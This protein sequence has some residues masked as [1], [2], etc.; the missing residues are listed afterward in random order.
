MKYTTTQEFEDAPRPN[1]SM[2]MPSGGTVY[3]PSRYREAI[4]N[5]SLLRRLDRPLGTCEANQYK[6]PLS[7]GMFRANVIES[8]KPNS[9]F[10][11]ELAFPM[12]CMRNSDYDCRSEAQKEAWSRSTS[13]FNNA[14]KQERYSKSR[15]DLVKRSGPHGNHAN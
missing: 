4:D 7:G 10:V 8:R 12:A 15:P 6:V 11:Q 14:T 9:R 1:D 5:E 13:L 3:P 2:V